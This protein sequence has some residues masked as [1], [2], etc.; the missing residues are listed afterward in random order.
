[1]MYIPTYIC[2]F[3]TYTFKQI[4][5]WVRTAA[6]QLL[7]TYIESIFPLSAF[8]TTNNVY[9]QCALLSDRSAIGDT[10]NCI[11]CVVVVVDMWIVL[12]MLLRLR[13]RTNCHASKVSSCIFYSKKTMK[14]HPEHALL[15]GSCAR[16][17]EK[18]I[19]II[20]DDTS[21]PP[22]DLTSILLLCCMLLL[23]KV[24]NGLLPLFSRSSWR[25]ATGVT[26]TASRYNFIDSQTCL[27]PHPELN[28]CQTTMVGSV[29]LCSSTTATA[30]SA[31]SVVRSRCP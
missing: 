14:M 7:V 24:D 9:V 18:K 30:T 13:T 1:M 12:F 3:P 10:F 25:M 2:S 27:S 28:V 17:A 16:P 8:A 20:H 21:V 26:T 23:F 19:A 31:T 22:K 6:L 15:L 29:Y 5:I 11:V 4:D